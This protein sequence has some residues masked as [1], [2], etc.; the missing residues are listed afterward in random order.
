MDFEWDPEK[1][2]SN[3]RKHGIAFLEASEVFGDILSSTVPDPDHSGEELRFLI[4]GQT[5][6][7]K[8]LVVAYTER[9]RLLRIISARDMT[10]RERKAY[11]Q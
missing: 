11:E 4:F 2:L 1:A 5:M 9:N 10:A 3:V 8:H 7:G 6:A